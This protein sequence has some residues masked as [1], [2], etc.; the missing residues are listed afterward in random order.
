MQKSPV[1]SIKRIMI[2]YRQN[3][4]RLDNA[5]YFVVENK[6]GEAIGLNSIYPTYNAFVL[7]NGFA[8]Y[9]LG[10]WIM[11]DSVSVLQSLES[12][13][14]TKKAFYEIL[15]LDDKNIFTLYFANT[16]VLDYLLKTGAVDVGFDEKEKLQILLLTREAYEQSKKEIFSLLNR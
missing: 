15:H 13:F 14:L 5:W 7:E 6:K 3:Y 1:L 8:F 10:R 16:Q 4:K 11:Q 2:Y 12:D 9:E